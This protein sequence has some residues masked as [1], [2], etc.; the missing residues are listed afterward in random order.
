[1][2]KKITISIRHHIKLEDIKDWLNCASSG[3]KYWAGNALC[4]ESETEKALTDEGVEIQ[5]FEEGD[6]LNPK[7]HILNLKKIKKG[8]T[9]MAK[10]YPK[11]FADFLKEDYD[12]GTGD[13]FLQCCLFG[14]IIYG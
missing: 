1:M 10:K 14:E 9:I 6:D 3:V 8:L 11:H 2:N 4:F 13:V 12:N 5:D 7:I